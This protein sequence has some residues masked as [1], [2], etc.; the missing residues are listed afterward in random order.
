MLVYVDT[1]VLV[2]AHTREPHTETAQ[3]WLAGQSGGG[4]I[5][6]VWTL[7]ECESAL[8]I[9]QRRGELDAA[10]QMAAMTEID[11]LAGCFAPATT[12]TEADHRRARELCQYAPSGL[13]A[14][15]ALH[16]A[17]ARRLQTSHFATLDQTLASN[18]AAHGLALSIPMIK[19]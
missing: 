11:A 1:S 8:T 4:V 16:L 6:S 12:P 13:R 15:D 19:P 9:K 18:A 10:G 7:L 14:G 5:V 2:A 17:I 3:A